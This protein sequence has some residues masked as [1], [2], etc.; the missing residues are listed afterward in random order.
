[1]GIYNNTTPYS[2]VFIFIVFLTPI[3]HAQTGC[4]SS[5]YII[6]LPEP[7]VVTDLGCETFQVCIEYNWDCTEV[8]QVN[9]EV[10]ISFDTRAFEV[11]NTGGFNIIRTDPNNPNTVILSTNNLFQVI[12]PNNRTTICFT[13]RPIFS[14]DQVIMFAFFNE[15]GNSSIGNNEPL[16]WFNQSQGF[17][18]LS[19]SL[20]QNFQ[21]GNTNLINP[22]LS[23]NSPAAQTWFVED[24][25]II[26][27]D[28]C[29]AGQIG[30]QSKIRF[31]P[32]GK[33]I[34]NPRVTFTIDETDISGCEE[35][36]D[37]IEVQRFGRLIISNSTIEDGIKAIDAKIASR[38][39]LDNVIFKNNDIGL[40]TADR[41]VQISKFDNNTFTA[42]SLKPPLEGSGQAA[43]WLEDIINTVALD[44]EGNK[45]SKIENGVV[46]INTA[47]SLKGSEIKDLTEGG[48]F[49]KFGVYA[50][51]PDGPQKAMTIDN[52]SFS[53]LRTAIR[54]ETM[55]STVKNCST[56][57]VENG[58]HGLTKGQA[59]IKNNNISATKH[60]IFAD[61]MNL[62]NISENEL[63]EVIGEVG[64]EEVSFGVR[65]ESPG[66]TLARIS[67]NE[68]IRGINAGNSIRMQ[69]GN[70]LF[71]EENAVFNTYIRGE[72]INVSG[73]NNIRLYCNGVDGAGGGA[74]NGIFDIN[75][76]GTIECN[77]T[78]GSNTGINFSGMPG[79]V[80]FKGNS[81]MGNLSQGLLINGGGT[82]IGPQEH[83]GNLWFGTAATHNGINIFSS[84]FTV[85]TITPPDHPLLNLAPG[86]SDW[87]LLDTEGEAFECADN[88]CGSGF[89]FP[90]FP[91]FECEEY[92]VLDE[93]IADGS[94]NTEEMRVGNWW[95]AQRQLLDKIRIPCPENPPVMPPDI[96]AFADAHQNSVLGQ[97]LDITLGIRALDAT[98]GSEYQMVIDIQASLENDLAIWSDLIVQLENQNLTQ[99]ERENLIQQQQN[100][101]AN[102]ENL[103][104]QK[105]V[106]W[107]DFKLAKNSMANQLL[108]QNT[109][110]EVAS[111]PAQNEQ[112]VNSIYL[113]TI[114]IGTELN[115][116]Q[117]ST[118]FA[119]ASQCP[120]DGGISVHKA[121]AMY[122]H[123]NPQAVFTD[124]DCEIQNEFRIGNPKNNNSKIV[125]TEIAPNPTDGLININFLEDGFRNIKVLNGLGQ[126]LFDTEK[127]ENQSQVSIDLSMYKSGIYFIQIWDENILEITEKVSLIK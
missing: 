95:N 3:S 104:I 33:I 12:A 57:R 52:C 120:Q 2:F 81:M 121:R 63:I 110:I 16:Q 72:G 114:A 60:G 47:F 30:R 84:Q 70:I 90:D 29:L 96:A 127:I 27:T 71:A 116:E 53:N 69:S 65:I 97:L 103:Q 68:S 77:E 115:V 66:Q 34:V 10:G 7:F 55:N 67:K 98:E 74:S 126:L 44:G 5:D 109:A 19:G 42:S 35:M 43:V 91:E 124:D 31:A 80:N 61:D 9:A 101:I 62:L 92:T 100:I 46:S 99:I 6:N 8:A 59:T 1:M 17:S 73:I 11:I 106:A 37:K 32:G 108:A 82:S 21:S 75:S 56:E 93:S 88:T 125:K 112:T 76:R 118:L 87:F 85:H 78:I 15:L 86:I 83:H 122:A 38:V 54:A 41:L 45:I 4:L 51:T 22:I 94:L 119:I 79:N 39:S 105:T 40:Y 111:I 58:F 89:V 24:E 28:Y 113:Q 25:L 20:L 50:F 107:N 49:S 102:I 18:M 117:L 13:V 123:I 14:G 64:D 26:D 36:W 48:V 23:C